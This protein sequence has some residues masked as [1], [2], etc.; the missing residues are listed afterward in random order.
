[1]NYKILLFKKYRLYNLIARGAFGTVFL[2]ENVLTKEKVAIKIEER[3][4]LRISL[5]K[6]AYILY[7]LKGPGLP[8]IKSFGRIKNYN[9]LVETLLGRSLYQIF[10]DCQ[11]KFTIKDVCM[12]GLQMIERI[13][14]VHSKNYIHRD[15][16][17]HNF[18]VSLKNEGQ[19]YIIDFGLS[20]KYK[21]DR[22]NHVKFNITKHLTGT[23]RFCSINS[24]RGVEQSRRDD[25]E[26]LSYLIL[27]FCKGYLPWQ[28]LKISSK[29]RRLDS[30]TDMKKKLNIEKFCQGLPPEIIA[31]YKYTRKLGFA[32]N[33][34]YGYMKNLLYSILNKNGLTDDKKFTWIKEGANTGYDNIYNYHLHKKSPH[35]RLIQK[36][37]FSLEQK[38]KEKANKDFTLNALYIDNNK[39]FE[40]LEINNT[41]N[42]FSIG[43]KKFIQ[44]NDNNILQNNISKLNIDNYKH[45]YNYP[46]VFYNKMNLDSKDN[47][48]SKIA[49]N[50]KSNN[51]NLQENLMNFPDKISM[52]EA[53][54]SNLAN[55]QINSNSQLLLIP[56]NEEDNITNQNKGI[57]LHDFIRKEEKEGGVIGKDFDY[58]END[59]FKIN[60]PLFKTEIEETRENENELNKIK[61]ENK[62][63]DNEE[64]LKTNTVPNLD[65][66]KYKIEKVSLVN[67]NN[68]N[69]QDNNNSNKNTLDYSKNKY[70]N[71][72]KSLNNKNPKN[73][74]NISNSI[75]PIGKRGTELVYF[76]NYSCQN[77]PLQANSLFPKKKSSFS[78]K[79]KNNEKIFSSNGNTNIIKT[80]NNCL[81]NIF[82]NNPRT[83]R[84]NNDINYIKINERKKNSYNIVKS[85]SKDNNYQGRIKQNNYDSHRR[86]VENNNYLE[87]FSD[88]NNFKKNNTNIIL[89]TSKINMK[90]ISDLN[91]NINLSQ[92]N[93]Y[94]I[95]NNDKINKNVNPT[96]YININNENLINKNRNKNK[97]FYQR[98][99]NSIKNKNN[100]TAYIGINGKNN[101]ISDNLSNINNTN[102]NISI[103]KNLNGYN[104]QK[105]NSTNSMN[106]S[107]RKKIIINNLIIKNNCN[108]LICNNNLYEDENN[109]KKK[110]CKY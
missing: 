106:N 15:I 57:K 11:K 49:H 3:N 85:K 10:N 5:E 102:H 6:E 68:N 23:P 87:Q 45:S 72:Y 90:R 8:E 29:N 78:N 64:Q 62:N 96:N 41:V 75:S 13:E 24:M 7:Y 50:F 105:Y 55:F 47:N 33:P 109:N 48:F 86:K 92:R 21:S 14:Y 17:P 103:N 79:N 56:E 53:T 70:K 4:K 95:I 89:R 81:K 67:L 91:N 65:D 58:K 25:L 104:N 54:K 101:T 2:G 82:N 100:N 63:K 80:E 74:I 35:K 52:I 66:N 42:N 83:Q 18:L 34:K 59:Y 69:N 107:K 43:S 27:Y 39:K 60:A 22:G 30:V 84:N 110:F 51:S 108:T 71:N 98:I 28:G 32:E 38:Q 93:E 16:K 36:I 77:N 26:S 61:N 76:Q 9:I 99:N 40:D 46:L 88:I 31:F 73:K 20:K 97:H 44:S 19:I 12:I 37:K 94:N 1:M